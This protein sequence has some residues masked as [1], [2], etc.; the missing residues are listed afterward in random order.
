VGDQHHILVVVSLAGVRVQLVPLTVD[1][2][3]LQIAEVQQ[4]LTEARK[5]AAPWREKL[6]A[7]RNDRNLVATKADLLRKQA[8]ASKERHEQIVADME[9]TKQELQQGSAQL[10]GL[11]KASA[12]HKSTAQ[13]ESAAAKAAQDAMAAT[14]AAV[15]EARSTA[16]GLSMAMQESRS[17]G[18]LLKSLMHAQQRGEISVCASLRGL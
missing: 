7:I 5:K 6:Q 9:A 10:G 1:A 4:R 16:A 8:D 11:E 14:E 15:A 18:S 13:R 17:Q 2:S 3:L 12:A